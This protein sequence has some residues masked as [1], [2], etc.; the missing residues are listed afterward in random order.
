MAINPVPWFE[1]YVE[2]IDRAKLFYEQVFQL[3]LR[4]LPAPFPGIELWAFPSDDGSYGASGALVRMDGR[5]SGGNS[6]VVY[7]HCQDCAIEEARAKEHGGSI[8]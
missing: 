8:Q 6:T 2:D 1:I 7:F 4:N 3:E 5:T